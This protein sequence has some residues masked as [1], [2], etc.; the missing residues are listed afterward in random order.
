MVEGWA[1][2]H[3]HLTANGCARKWASQ[4][5]ENAANITAWRDNIPV[6]EDSEQDDDETLQ[7]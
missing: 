7:V 4:I 6:Q 5:G 1:L 3:A 2:I